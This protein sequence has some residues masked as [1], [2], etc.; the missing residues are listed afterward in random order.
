LADGCPILRSS[1][2][3]GGSALDRRPKIGEVDT[4]SDATGV[5]LLTWLITGMICAVIA[6][7]VTERKNRNSGGFFLLALIFPIIGLIAALL[8]TPGDPPPPE[9]TKAVIC[10]RCN[11]KQNVPKDNQT[12]ACWQCRTAVPT[13]R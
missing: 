10:P 9:G 12:Y 2:P 4:A 1:Q 5:L 8:V 13:P 7:V 6:G 11:A 3:I